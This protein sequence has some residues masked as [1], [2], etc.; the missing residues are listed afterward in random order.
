MRWFLFSQSP[1][2]CFAPHFEPLTFSV[3][4][5]IITPMR[6]LINQFIKFGL[7]GFL[8][9]C[10]D[11]G[12]GLIVLNIVMAVASAAFFETAS[13]IASV[14]GFSVSVVVNYLLSM[15]FV[16]ERK[17]DMNRKAEFV[18]FVIL[19]VVGLIINA[20]IIWVCV[21]PIYGA[22]T[23]LQENTSYN[24]VY[25]GAKLIATVIVM[26]YNFITR[27]IFLEQR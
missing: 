19:S 2:N 12:I 13:V 23:F 3:F 10:I 7:V 21:G 5:D 8:S 26:I 27:K 14:V 11:Y 22:S 18:I 4:S 1:V 16:F 9:F 6:K 15:K 25:T 17:E 24:V 20:I